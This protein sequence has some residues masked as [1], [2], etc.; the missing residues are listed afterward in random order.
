MGHEAFGFQGVV[1]TQRPPVTPGTSEWIHH[2]LC[3][4]WSRA[5]FAFT[6]LHSPAFGSCLEFA[7]PSTDL[8]CPASCNNLVDDSN[9]ELDLDTTTAASSHALSGKSLI[10]FQLSYHW[11]FS[12][13]AYTKCCFF[14]DSWKTRSV[15][16]Q[17]IL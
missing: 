8:T 9:L 11:H 10:L 16:P 2:L 15:F 12:C 3:V 4:T 1:W 14:D 5:A 13:H 7:F 6:R 17:P